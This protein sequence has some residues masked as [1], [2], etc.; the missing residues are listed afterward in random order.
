MIFTAEGALRAAGEGRRNECVSQSA[1]LDRA[2][3]V[4]AFVP[5]AVL[6]RHYMFDVVNA[7]T[8]AVGCGVLIAYFPGIVR[9]L[10]QPKWE[11]SHYLVLGVFVTW[12]A[13][14]LRHLW[15]WLWRFLAKPPDMIDHWFVALLV[16]VTF[17]GGVLHL[18]A[19]GAIDGEIPR[20]YW[21]RLGATVAAGIAVALLVII[22]LEPAVPPTP[23]MR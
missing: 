3:G 2:C 18:T 1:V 12:V 16:W 19:K 13:T 20:E 8:V 7:L 14:D 22:F 4:V 23:R 15:N 5:V 6:P 11:G 9:S 21:I 17:L 10:A